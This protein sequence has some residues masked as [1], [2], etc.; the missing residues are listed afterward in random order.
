M[1]FTIYRDFASVAFVRCISPISST[2]VFAEGSGFSVSTAMEKCRSEVVE[3]ELQLSLSDPSSV[4]G[5]A[6]HPSLVSAK[7][8]AWNEVLETL[9]LERLRSQS[10]FG[11]PLCWGEQKF[12]LGRIQDRFAA[13][14]I[15]PH[16]GSTAGVQCIDRNPL[17]AILKTW[18]ERRN[19][20]IYNPP[21][22]SLLSYTKAN[23]ILSAEG[24][25]AAQF[26][27]TLAPNQIS[28]PQLSMHCDQR[29]NRHIVFFTKEAL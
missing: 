21:A 17:K 13:I 26:R 8:N 1:E 15:F 4:L 29:G 27:L 11:L 10:F 2:K 28:V 7:E 16:D 24:L 18:T 20:T 23:R 14:A 3:R 5:I 25:R 19:L 12:W 9:L 6:A 22:S